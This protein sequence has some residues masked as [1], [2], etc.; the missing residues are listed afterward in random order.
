M[1]ATKRAELAMRRFIGPSLSDEH[2]VW[3]NAAVVA[4]ALAVVMAFAEAL[5]NLTSTVGRR[6]VAD[7]HEPQ[8]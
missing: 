3:S 4:A 7:D 8:C 6:I 1:V 5:R 2:R